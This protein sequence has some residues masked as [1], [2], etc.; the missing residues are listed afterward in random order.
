M[1][2]FRITDPFPAYLN[3]AGQ[4]ADGGS[5]KFYDS[6][7]TTPR[8]V[9]G[10]PA[11]SVNNG[12]S[13]LIGS[14]G[15]PVH[16]IWGDGSYRVRLYDANDTLID[17]ADDVE[18]QGGGGTAI[19]ALESGK[20]LTNDGAT[21]QWEELRQAPDPTGS[22]DKILSNDGANY[23]WIDK[24]SNGTTPDVPITVGTTSVQIGNTSG[25]ALL[26][27]KGSDSA[28][29][30]GAIGTSKTVTF[31]TAYAS[32]A[33]HVSVT[34]TADAQAGGL[35]V[36]TL[37]S[38]ASTTGFTVLFDVAEGAGAS[39]KINNAVPFTWIAFGLVDVTP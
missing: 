24:P 39:A 22:A 29:A 18:I 8:D 12:S 16:D 25:K 27:Q 31:P 17:E 19:P 4:L 9:Y 14:D 21:L 30:T 23:I 3:L 15:R 34:P 20:F 13:V 26:I 36:H 1:A 6:G 35:V 28:P 37:T 38:A 2:T 10:D 7:T 33:W 5:L 11:K 32:A